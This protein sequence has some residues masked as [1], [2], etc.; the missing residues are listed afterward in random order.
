MRL[1][2]VEVVGYRLCF[3][4]LQCESLAHEAAKELLL[5]LFRDERF[6]AAAAEYG[7][8]LLRREAVDICGRLMQNLR[9]AEVAAASVSTETPSTKW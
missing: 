8:Q 9:H 3:G 4:L 6:F 5:R 1:R 7:A 2:E